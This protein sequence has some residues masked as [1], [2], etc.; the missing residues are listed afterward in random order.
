[1]LHLPNGFVQI[2]LERSLVQLEQQLALVDVVAFVE[3]DFLDLSVDLRSN[4]HSLKGFDV[5]DSKDL[6]RNISLFDAGGDDR[7]GWSVPRAP[8]RLY[9]WFVSA[10]R[11]GEDGN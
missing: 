10:S 9:L 1:V 2:R 4:L 11:Q 7:S 3:E 5:A 6:N 8:G